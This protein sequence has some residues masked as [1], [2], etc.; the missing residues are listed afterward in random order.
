M[1][2][3]G[4]AFGACGSEPAHQSVTR[5][6][7]I[8]AA[9]SRCMRDNAASVN[10]DFTDSAKMA[11]MLKRT[12][13]AR[14]QLEK[15]LKTLAAPPGDS[16]ALTAFFEAFDRDLA[17]LQDMQAAASQR[18]VELT[19]QLGPTLGKRMQEMETVAAAYGFQ[20]CGR[21]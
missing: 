21:F 20:F 13:A 12:I 4:F 6:S 16:A 10:L 19:N 17:A 18:N 15:D 8:R 1:V 3:L 11:A 2:A 7:F 9:D 14:T 5:A